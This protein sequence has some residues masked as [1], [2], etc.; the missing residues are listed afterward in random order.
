M[1]IIDVK[2]TMGTIWISRPWNNCEEIIISDPDDDIELIETEEQNECNSTHCAKG[3]SD[4]SKD[5]DDCGFCYTHGDTEC[6]K[7]LDYEDCDMCGVC[8]L[9]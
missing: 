1:R 8:R 7:G 9:Y 5:C 4:P 2:F 6:L 3:Y